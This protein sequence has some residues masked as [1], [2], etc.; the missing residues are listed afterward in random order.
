MGKAC[1]SL[2]HM[3]KVNLDAKKER[4]EKLYEGQYQS[5]L[6]KIWFHTKR[7]LKRILHFLR[8][9][10]KKLSHFMHPLDHL[11][12]P[13]RLYTQM[14]LWSLGLL[15]LNSVNI[16]SAAYLG[17]EGVGAQ[18]DSLAL[19]IENYLTNEDGYLIKNMPLEGEAV[20][21]MDRIERVVY[22][23]QPGDTLSLI[24]YRYGLSVDSLRFEN[25]A[26]ANTD[27]LKPGQELQIPPKDGVY[28]KVESGDSLLELM[29]KYDGKLEETKMFNGIDGD[30]DLVAGKE[31]FIVD[32]SLPQSV[33]T[34]IAAA[35]PSTSQ[36]DT[37]EVDHSL[38]AVT[39]Y[40]ITPSAEGWIRPVPGVITQGYSASHYAYDVADR[41][42][43]PVLA[44]ASGTV[45]T[46]SNGA[47][48]GGYG[49]YVIIDHGN[50]YQTLYAHTEIVYVNV[51][52]Y[53]EQ[54]QVIAKMGNTGRVYG[55]TGI[56]THFELRFNG[57]KLSP[58][59]MGV[60]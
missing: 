52:D 6:G 10:R 54:G 41:S 1:G 27:K 8:P 49:N 36:A 32:G 25:D 40:N 22:E 35:P 20:Y 45:V 51:G 43:P 3:T 44:A 12:A 37:T 34:Y 29:E 18:Y 39:Q 42:R 9:S 19:D 11:P 15:I 46:A 2:F 13:K 57:T 17:G 53:V 30:N 47:W 48:N 33:N 55:V 50:G 31:I 5:K 60:W 58:S 23:V 4:H 21:D 56:H 7:A 28:I 16:S 26:I 24:A 38:P 14:V 59:V